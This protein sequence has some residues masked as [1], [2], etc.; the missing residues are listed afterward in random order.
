M[1]L[2]L[3]PY[4]ESDPGSLEAV[5]YVLVAHS[6]PKK[7]MHNYESTLI[8][9]QKIKRMNIIDVQGPNFCP[10]RQEEDCEKTKTRGPR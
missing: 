10:S 4:V 6:K 9:T 2:N 3:V 1:T 5:F 8:S 7:A